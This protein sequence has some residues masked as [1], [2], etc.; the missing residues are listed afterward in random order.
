[1]KAILYARFSPRRNAENCES[2]EHQLADLREYCVKHG[3]EIIGEYADKALSGGDYDRPGLW[4]AINSI[5]QGQMLLIRHL[6][7]LARDVYL[8]ETIVREIRQRKAILRVTNGAGGEIGNKDDPDADLLRQILQAVAERQRKVTAA[9]TKAAMLR[10]QASGIRM[11]ARLPYGW[12]LDE[13][14]PRNDAGTPTR[15]IENPD[16]QRVITALVREY[17]ATKRLAALGAIR[18]ARGL[19]ELGRFLDDAGVA[20]PYGRQWQHHAIKSIFQ[21]AG[22]L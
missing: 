4:E 1:M 22:A 3:H 6:D 16:E 19:R 5:K 13:A 7:R 14:G 15:M 2:V 21:R 12:K 20:P 10:K 18:K 9:L 17:T 11:S 8:C